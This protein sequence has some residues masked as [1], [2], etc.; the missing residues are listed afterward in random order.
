M[1][2]LRVYQAIMCRYTGTMESPEYIPRNTL[3]AFERADYELVLKL[4]MPFAIEVNSDAQTTVAL[5]VPVWPG[6][7]PGCIE[8]RTLAIES[9][10]EQQ[11]RCME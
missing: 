7:E 6:G 11:F 2:G 8:G 10:R 9:S 1:Y 3:E 4:A 5:P